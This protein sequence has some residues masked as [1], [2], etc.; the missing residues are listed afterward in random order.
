MNKECTAEEAG[1]D[2]RSKKGKSRKPG[3][4]GYKKR[5]VFLASGEAKKKV[6]SVQ[7]QLLQPTKPVLN[8]KRKA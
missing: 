6:P 8:Q 2:F 4:M 5:K 7:N 1:Y 3:G